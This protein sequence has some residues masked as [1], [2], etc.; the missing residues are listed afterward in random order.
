[1]KKLIS[2]SLCL[3]LIAPLFAGLSGNKAAYR[4]GTVATLKANQEGV[5]VLTKPEGFSFATLSVPYNQ[6]QSI[7]Y[8]Q[9]AGRRVGAAIATALIVSPVGLFLL[10]SKKR[11]HIVSLT[12]TNAEGKTDAAVFEVGKDAIRSTLK[13]LEVRTGKTIEYESADARANIGK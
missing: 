2:L 12:W 7:E 5:L 9:K 4:G 13:V 10:F 11:R 3:T 1:V 8:G 6:V